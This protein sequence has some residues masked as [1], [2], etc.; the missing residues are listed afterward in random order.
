MSVI[1]NWLNEF[2]DSV[3]GLLYAALDGSCAWSPNTCNK[4]VIIVSGS[5]FFNVRGPLAKGNKIMKKKGSP[6]ASSHTDV[7]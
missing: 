3:V 7:R 6:I 1:E 2:P 5:I 4:G